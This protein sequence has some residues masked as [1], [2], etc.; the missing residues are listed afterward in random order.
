MTKKTI[1]VRKD[2]YGGTCGVCGCDVLLLWDKEP[3]MLSCMCKDEEIPTYINID[4]YNRK[5]YL[6]RFKA[7]QIDVPE[8]EKS[9]DE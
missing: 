5:Q 2:E 1:F 3:W 6:K 7:V 9:N 8:G 4:P